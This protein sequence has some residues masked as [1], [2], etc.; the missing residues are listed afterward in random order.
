MFCTSLRTA[1]ATG[2]ALAMSIDILLHRA[3]IGAI[4]AVLR[5]K[6]FD[7]GTAKCF[8]GCHVPLLLSMWVGAAIVAWTVQSCLNGQM[9]RWMSRGVPSYS[10]QSLNATRGKSEA[11]ASSAQQ[12]TFSYPDA[13][14]FNFFD[15]DNLPEMMNPYAEVVFS[16]VQ[17]LAKQY[18]FQV[19]CNI[20]FDMMK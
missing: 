18:G 7:I 14:E 12:R 4:G 16:T 15:P 3:F 9:K 5:M 11:K 2:L 8:S 20:F 1:L 10:Y 6:S 19:K 13:L 17:S